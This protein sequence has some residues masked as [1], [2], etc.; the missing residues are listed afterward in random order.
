MTHKMSGSLFFDSSTGPAHMRL[1][2]TVFTLNNQIK[3]A[4]R[5]STYQVTQTN[6][7]QEHQPLVVNH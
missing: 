1:M 6:D 7:V 5:E 3:S 2:N 4:Q